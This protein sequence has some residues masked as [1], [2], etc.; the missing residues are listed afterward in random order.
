M[1][2]SVIGTLAVCSGILRAWPQL[3]RIV[4]HRN[5][6]GVSGLTWLLSLSSFAT[7][8]V[9]ALIDDVTPA[10][11]YNIFG[12]VSSLAVLVVLVWQRAM[13]WHTPLVGIA[14]TALVNLCVYWLLDRF[15]VHALGVGVSMSMFI[16]QAVAVMRSPSAGVS[17]VTWWLAAITSA[18]WGVY[19]LLSGEYVF[20]VPTIVM[21]PASLVILWQLRLR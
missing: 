20:A 9:I 5:A 11:V 14:A 4:I 19:G 2:T 7:W 15:G 1:L 21:L 16:P 10:L 3:A 12:I 18:L 8:E 6:D 13:K 17:A